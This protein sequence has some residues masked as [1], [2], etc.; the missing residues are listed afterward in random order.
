VTSRIVTD[1]AEPGSPEWLKLI[2]ASKIPSILG[3]SRFKSQYTLWHE[4]AGNLEPEQIGKAQQDDFDY[5]HA[6]ELAA[7]EYWKLRN[8]G[9]RLSPGEVQ[10]TD[11]ALPFGNAATIDA[12]ASRGTHRRVVE[13]KTARDIYEYGD[14]GTGIVPIDYEAQIIFQQMVSG[15]LDPADLVLWPQYGKPKIYHIEYKA[16][17]AAAILSAVQKWNDSL[18]N[19]VAPDLDDSISTYETVRRLN[20]KIDGTTVQLTPSLAAEFL[21]VDRDFE[22]LEARRV[23]LKSKVLNEMGLAQHA[24]VIRH[25]DGAE[26]HEHIARRQPARGG[27]IALYADKKTD[28]AAIERLSA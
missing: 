15:W 16:H 2:T 24:E 13:K 10:Y 8:P 6:A 19:G 7:G 11:I 5:G 20:P 25:I 21:Q 18:A 1:K 3:I 4:M 12:R 9:W 28:I 26:V 14:D 22:A 27:S 23:G 17:V